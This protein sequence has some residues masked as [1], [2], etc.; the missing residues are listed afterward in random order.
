MVSILRGAVF[1]GGG[2]PVRHEIHVQDPNLRAAPLFLKKHRAAGTATTPGQ[3]H[4]V[5][6]NEGWAFGLGTGVGAEM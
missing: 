3:I 5:H 1:H 4:W 6:L 2:A